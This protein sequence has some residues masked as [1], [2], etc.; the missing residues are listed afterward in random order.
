MS[1][2]EIYPKFLSCSSVSTDTRK[3]ERDAMFFALKGPNFNANNFAKKALE[4][5]AKYVVID[6]EKYKTDDRYILVDDALVCLQQLAL[7]HR[8]QLGI[9]IIAITGSNGKTTTK[10][11]INAVLKKKYNTY[12]TIGNLNNHIGVPLTLLAIKKEV[13]IGIVEM[14]A[15][16]QNEISFYCSIAEPTHGIIT[17][18]GKAHLEGFGGLEGVKKG[19]GELF[20]YLLKNKGIAF[21][22]SKDETV[23]SIS[24]FSDFVSYPE[25]D[26]FYHCTL[27]SDSPFV[28]FLAENGVQYPTNLIGRYNFSNIAA[29]LCIGK[30]FNVSNE[31]AN[32]AVSEYD[33][34]NN[35]SQIVKKGT[36]S[37]ILDAYNANP[38]SMSA[39][40]ENF[41]KLEAENKLMI[42]GAMFELGNE[43]EKEHELLGIL[44]REKKINTIFCGNDMRYAKAVFPESQ[45]FEERKQLENWLLENRINNTTILLKGSRGM[46]LEKLLDFL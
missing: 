3:I 43:S 38:S 14:G 18:I 26:D 30:Y 29:A 7:L 46:G 31:D 21:I 44:T 36:N 2:S 41:A 9:P 20:D 17:N 35:R 8:R 33:P 6:E 25:S 10:E 4:D 23:R 22:N 5:G 40:I 45:Y 13:E 34:Q 15:N 37:I 24:R 32:K 12:A 27:V 28:V 16:H 42:L 1:V 39:A 11:L 19:K